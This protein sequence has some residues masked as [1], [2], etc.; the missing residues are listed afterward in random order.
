MQ[1]LTFYGSVCLCIGPEAKRDIC[2]TFDPDKPISIHLDL[3]STERPP[4][5]EIIQEGK[6]LIY[7]TDFYFTNKS[8]S[9][10]VVLS[11]SQNNITPTGDQAA[12]ADPILYDTDLLQPG[13]IHLHSWILYTSQAPILDLTRKDIRSEKD[14]ENAFHALNLCPQENNEEKSIAEKI[15]E[16]PTNQSESLTDNDTSD[17]TEVNPRIKT[18]VEEREYDTIPGS[19]TATQIALSHSRTQANPT[20]EC[21]PLH[22][23]VKIKKPSTDR[24]KDKNIHAKNKGK[25]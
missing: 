10:I 23:K 21:G 12:A 7:T 17:D 20:V 22:W 9:N 8:P 25:K 5:V 1:L 19:A 13:E 3:P 18:S 4:L 14:I 15:Q 11:P 24:A 16:E 2:I 6:T